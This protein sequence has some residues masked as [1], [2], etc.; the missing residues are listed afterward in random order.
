MSTIHRFEDILAWQ[1]A[2]ILNKEIYGIS[3]YD[4]FIKA[5]ALKDQIR[6]SSISAMLNISEGFGRRS[7]KEF[8]YFLFISHGSIAEVQSC[9]Y[10]AL[11]LEYVPQDL[12][13]TLY[14][15]CNEISKI[16]SGLIKSLK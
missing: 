9:L 7:H 8:K 1:K 14:S 16:I 12:F 3:S 11:D 2:R 4:L 5:F 13:T 6:R 15:N 10:V